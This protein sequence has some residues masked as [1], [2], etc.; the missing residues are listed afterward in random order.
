M[1][2][3]VSFLYHLQEIEEDG[4]EDELVMSGTAMAARGY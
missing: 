3:E 4:I 2:L 1:D